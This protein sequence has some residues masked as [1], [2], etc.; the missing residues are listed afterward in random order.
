MAIC[1]KWSM[2]FEAGRLGNVKIW[3]C[4]IRRLERT[5][6]VEIGHILEGCF[7]KK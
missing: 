1:S 7:Q 6:N 3:Q 5:V 4:V 2:D